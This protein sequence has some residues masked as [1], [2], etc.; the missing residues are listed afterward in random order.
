MSFILLYLQDRRGL[1]IISDV[2]ILSGTTR[3]AVCTLLSKHITAIGKLA[4][5][6]TTH[7][8]EHKGAVLQLIYLTT[9]EESFITRAI[10]NTL[11]NVG[12]VRLVYANSTV[13]GRLQT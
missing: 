10:G 4:P 2:K 7:Q 13:P 9:R 11:E 8:T 6:R 3:R 5:L 1:D 12:F